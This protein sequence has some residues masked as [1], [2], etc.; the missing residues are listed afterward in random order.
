MSRHWT[1]AVLL[2]LT[3]SAFA[4]PDVREPAPAVTIPIVGDTAGVRAVYYSTILIENH[5]DREQ[6]IRVDF[7]PAN[8][9]RLT[10]SFPRYFNLPA[11]SITVHQTD[12]IHNINGLLPIRAI[13]AERIVTVTGE[14]VDDPEG[15]ISARATITAIPH[16]GGGTFRQEIEQVPDADLRGDHQS[17]TFLGAR[18]GRNS[19][20]NV[21]VVNLDWE[22]SA[23]YAVRV[24][25]NDLVYSEFTITA[26]PRSVA[27]ITAPGLEN[28]PD[29]LTVS[30]T[31][32]TSSSHKWTGYVSVVD[33][34]TGDGWTAPQIE[35]PNVI[36]G[37][38][39]VHFSCGL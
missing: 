25:K 12:A 3:T 8:G 39:N 27:Q 5:L 14:G 6:R 33:D 23:T 18:G 34:R 17:L 16:A 32:T 2:L 1:A 31:R 9:T 38:G 37:C 7:Y 24:T 36:L 35:Q 21:G 29:Y 10:S 22:N 13:G 26:A 11:R 20:T 4:A 30:I 19:R 28:A 15:R